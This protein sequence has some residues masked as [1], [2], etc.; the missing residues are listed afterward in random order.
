MH[1]PLFEL[2]QHVDSPR[3]RRALPRLA[4][5][6]RFRF[7]L[8]LLLLVSLV[9]GTSIG[10]YVSSLS[11]KV[12]DLNADNFDELVDNSRRPVLVAFTAQW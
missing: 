3:L 5:L 9:L 4:V 7:N 11:S 1:P 10:I 8:S 6:M 12:M 2:L